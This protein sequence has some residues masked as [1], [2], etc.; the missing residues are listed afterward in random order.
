MTKYDDGPD[1]C[2]TNKHKSADQI[3][4][5]CCARKCKPTLLERIITSFTVEC[6]YYKYQ[7][8]TY[9]LC[10]DCVHNRNRNRRIKIK[11]ANKYT[12]KYN[13]AQDNEI[14]SEDSFHPKY[15][16]GDIF[17]CKVCGKTFIACYADRDFYDNG[18]CKCPNCGLKIIIGK[19]DYSNGK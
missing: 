19:G 11:R 10:K 16:N 18:E 6:Q 2:G 4:I 17:K 12:T 7:C 1:K 9:H 3:M 13:C 15:V 5:D 14:I 8:T